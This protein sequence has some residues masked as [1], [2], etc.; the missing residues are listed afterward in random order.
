MLEKMQFDEESLEKEMDQ[1]PG[2]VQTAWRWSRN[3]MNSLRILMIWLKKQ[4][5]LAQE[6]DKGKER[7]VRI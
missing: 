1:D 4:E 5:E 6:S 7:T 3:S 2:A